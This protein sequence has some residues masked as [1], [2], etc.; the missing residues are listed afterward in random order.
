MVP[1]TSPQSSAERASG[2]IL[3]SVQES[4]IAPLRLTSPYVGRNPVTPQ[5]AAGV[6][7]DPEVSDPSANP[8]SPAAVAAAEPLEEPP[9]QRER[10]HGFSPEPVRDADAYR[11][12]PPPASSTIA[13]FPM[14]IAPP[15][16]SLSTTSA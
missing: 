7:I 2:P 4:A 14:R 5:N 8:T 13:S 10:S 15:L 16:L 12:P 11:Y 1:S 9:L 6:M 3:S